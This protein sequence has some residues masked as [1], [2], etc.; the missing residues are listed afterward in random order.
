M[1]KIKE[2]E[3]RNLESM[4]HDL[5]ELFKSKI[6]YTDIMCPTC[7]IKMEVTFKTDKL[8]K[9]IEGSI[10]IVREWE[11]VFKHGSSN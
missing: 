10:Q 8:K 6:P 7:L 11:E 1:G 3:L 5:W 4:L 9:P 2:R